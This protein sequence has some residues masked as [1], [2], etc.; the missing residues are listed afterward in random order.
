MVANEAPAPAANA[1]G[2]PGGEMEVMARMLAQALKRLDAQAAEI[3]ALRESVYSEG[4]DTG[5]DDSEGHEAQ[6]EHGEGPQETPQREASVLPKEQ[7]P[8]KDVEAVAVGQAVSRTRL[9]ELQHL[10]MLEMQRLGQLATPPRQ[11]P[12][13]QAP[14]GRQDLTMEDRRGGTVPP[15]GRTLRLG[16]MA[17]PP[18]MP[19][20]VDRSTDHFQR[21][22]V[23]AAH[24]GGLPGFVVPKV[25]NTKMMKLGIEPF[26]GT[27]IL[28]GLGSGFYEWGRR[29]LRQVALGEAQCGYGWSEG[30]RVECLGKNLAGTAAKYYTQNVEA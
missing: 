9:K 22:G 4:E 3:A 19:M 25:P 6:R 28:P 15:A 12:I 14:A 16:Q 17:N 21:E 2:N 18:A 8:A 30:I 1:V 11:E 26:D 29:F 5:N 27:E 13:G 10:Q 20:E 7:A 23:S 24:L